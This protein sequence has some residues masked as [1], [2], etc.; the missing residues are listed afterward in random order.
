[1]AMQNKRATFAKANM[2]DM[3]FFTNSIFYKI[4]FNLKYYFNNLKYKNNEKI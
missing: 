4:F 2:Q 3:H 1:M